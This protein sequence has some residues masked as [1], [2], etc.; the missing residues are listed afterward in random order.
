M[1][2]GQN[3]E[4]G[5]LDP[6]KRDKNFVVDDA[7]HELGIAFNVRG[8]GL[9][10]I[11]SCSHRGIIN[12]VRRAQAVSGIDKV[13]AI[14]GGFRLVP[15]QTREQAMETLALMQAI[16]PDYVIPGHCSGETFSSA[17]IAAMPDKV[18]RSNVET[19]YT[20]GIA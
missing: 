12:T 18:I 19:S 5:Q 15:P 1:L 13:H 2:P 4:R 17:A 10:V 8:R 14:V 6:T 11:G 3:C 20:F 9:V 7:E 16:N